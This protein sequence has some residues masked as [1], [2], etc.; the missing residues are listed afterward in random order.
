MPEFVW[1]P[2]LAW[3]VLKV[4]MGMWETPLRA[5]G[6]SWELVV[7]CGPSSAGQCHCAGST[8][9]QPGQVIG[10]LVL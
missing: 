5:K 4:F 2:T 9:E 6:S 1:D 10:L 3:G 8:P 7:E